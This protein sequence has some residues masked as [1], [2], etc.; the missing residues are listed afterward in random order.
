MKNWSTNTKE[1]ILYAILLGIILLFPFIQIGADALHSGVFQWSDIFKKWYNTLPFI[2]LI[3]IHATLLLPILLKKR[4]TSKYI[5]GVVLLVI[6]FS[7]YSFRKHN[8]MGTPLPDI[9]AYN[10]PPPHT[11]PSEE[12]MERT[13][14]NGSLRH[15]INMPPANHF[16]P[17]L[18][19]IDSRHTSCR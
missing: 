15:Q 12:I 2:I 16:I 18:V 19:V 11:A 17:G 13:P 14:Q 10:T 8:R 1:Y 5:V 3:A 7:V 6:L 9:A 4:K